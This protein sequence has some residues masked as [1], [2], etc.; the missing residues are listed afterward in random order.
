MQ[1]LS[2][3]FFFLI[4]NFWAEFPLILFVK[5][6]QTQ[7]PDIGRIIIIWGEDLEELPIYWQQCRYSIYTIY[8]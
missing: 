2:D 1:K 5:A 7:L 4:S 8:I 3:N 6:L